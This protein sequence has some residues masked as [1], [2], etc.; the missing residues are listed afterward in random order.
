MDFDDDDLDLVET[1]LF[2]YYFQGEISQRRRK[3]TGHIRTN[4][5]SEDYVLELLDSAYAICI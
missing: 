1:L 2:I 4:Y 3:N 5:P